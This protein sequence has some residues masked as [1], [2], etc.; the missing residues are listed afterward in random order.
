MSPPFQ[1]YTEEQAC[2]KR[3]QWRDCQAKVRALQKARQ[4][5]ETRDL[6]AA[7]AATEAAEQKATG[8]E[9]ALAR[10][11]GSRSAHREMRDERYTSLA[12]DMHSLE[13][14]VVALRAEEARLT[15]MVGQLRR[16]DIGG[17]IELEGRL[18]SLASVLPSGRKGLRLV[19]RDTIVHLYVRYGVAMH[20]TLPAVNF[21]LEQVGLTV[22]DDFLDSKQL[23]TRALIELAEM[24][25]MDLAYELILRNNPDFVPA[26]NFDCDPVSTPP[27]AQPV[28]IPREQYVPDAG[29][30]PYEH[31]VQ[32]RFDAW[33][34][35]G[36]I[37]GGL[38]S[39]VPGV[40]LG[41]YCVKSAVAGMTRVEALRGL[42]RRDPANCA[43]RRPA[44][45]EL[46][47]P[48]FERRLA[49]P[50]R[51]KG[52][53]SGNLLQPGCAHNCFGGD[54]SAMVTQPPFTAVCCAPRVLTPP[55]SAAVCC[56]ACANAAALRSYVLCPACANAAALRSCVLCRVC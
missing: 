9:R 48:P 54:G 55:P 15:L 53:D 34:D 16:Q 50:T 12:A 27:L 40:N 39:S 10:A 26:V 13:E 5:V 43:P 37:A 36:S 52:V 21:V 32:S 6:A 14:E 42:M 25:R 41:E 30:G 4:Q 23:T 11:H 56:A 3:R 44:D 19:L 47:A 17:L 7:R 49:A 51:G 45:P 8:A 28:P 35:A 18:Y 22:L 31:E 33:V 24:E 29:P 2:W 46:P 20:K 1:R 38:L